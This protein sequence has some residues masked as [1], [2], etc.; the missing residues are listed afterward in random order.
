MDYLPISLNI[1]NASCLVIGGGN[2]ALR[3]SKQLLSACAKVTVVAPDFHADLLQLEMVGS[4]RLVYSEYR[5]EQVVG[6][7]LVIAATD[8]PLINQQV[9][10]D[11]ESQGVLVN[12]VDQPELCRFIVP[13]IID[14]SPLTV[15]IST[16]GS[17]PVFARMLR[18]KLEWLIPAN[19]GAFLTRV[20]SDRPLVAEHYPELPARRS[21]WESFFER[22]LSWSTSQNLST[23]NNQELNLKYQLF[24]SEIQNRQA[25]L[26]LI[27]FGRRDIN[28]L[29]VA[30]IRQLQKVDHLY[31]SQENYRLIK[32]LVRRDADIHFIEKN[33]SEYVQVSALIEEL[34]DKH[35]RTVIMNGGH[36]FE[37]CKAKLDRL[38]ATNKKIEYVRIGIAKYP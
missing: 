32:D 15:A 17:G 18:E 13:S 23:S 35:S 4:I 25:Q 2:I 31:V 22:E 16:G 5:S 12:V 10:S 20:N 9:H 38:L 30:A 33:L 8:D 34:N 29:S 7:I 28:D 1:K 37:Q 19:I 11:A 24:E 14:R 3:K 6:Q 36:L 26:A 21:F 27:D